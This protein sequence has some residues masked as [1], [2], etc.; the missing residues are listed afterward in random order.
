MQ[1][2]TLLITNI[3]NGPYSPQVTTPDR[4]PNN[5]VS[6]QVQE[7]IWGWCQMIPQRLRTKYF[8]RH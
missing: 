3:I 8:E 2:T 6:Q 5:L 1:F 7:F 4:W